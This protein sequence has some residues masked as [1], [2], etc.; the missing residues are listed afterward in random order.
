MPRCRATF[1]ISFYDRKPEREPLIHH[2]IRNSQYVSIRDIER[3]AE[4]RIWLGKAEVIDRRS[5][6][7]TCEAVE[8]ATLEWVQWFLSRKQGS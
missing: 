7:N 6:W 1:W 2:S 4:T 8:L 3:L 5:S